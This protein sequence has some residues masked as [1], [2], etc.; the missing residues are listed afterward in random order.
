MDLKDSEIG[1][2]HSTKDLKK[3]K[4]EPHS[5]RQYTRSLDPDRT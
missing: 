4:K 3:K 5:A 1:R 2:A